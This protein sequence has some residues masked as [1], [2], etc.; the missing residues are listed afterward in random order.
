MIERIMAEPEISG[1]L[2]SVHSH[3]PAVLS[4]AAAQVDDE[5]LRAYPVD[6]GIECVL[7]KPKLIIEHPRGDD[8]MARPGIEV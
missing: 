3:D 4:A 7:G 6:Q 5:T 2:P 8:D 1:S